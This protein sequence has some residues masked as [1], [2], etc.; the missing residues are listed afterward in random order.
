MRTA[1]LT[2]ALAALM[3]PVPALPALSDS[4]PV[5]R[6]DYSNPGVTPAHWTLMINP[7]G[8]G[9]F[10]SER[11]SA[12]ASN[13][14]TLEAPNVDR[15]VRLSGQ[16]AERVFEEV[17]LQAQLGRDCESHLK[18]AFQ[19]WKKFSYSGPEGEW[20]CE[21]NYSRDKQVQALGDQLVAV[22][23]TILEGARLETL[24]QH[25]RLG[26][27]HETEFM[28]EASGDGRLLQIC[29]IRSILERLASDDEVMERVRKRA[30]QLLA[31]ADK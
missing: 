24:M 26:L 8:S 30:R 10:Q 17:H 28:M 13:P 21:F 25:D 23:S 6:V 22:A 16:F 20:T 27:D 15:D 5:F 14:P 18:V 2:A 31:R 7:D 12:P 9:H 19:G 11:G 29:A 4:G 3:A 1:L